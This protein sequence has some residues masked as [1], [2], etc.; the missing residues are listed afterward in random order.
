MNI[1]RWSAAAAAITALT[2]T[3]CASHG[4]NAGFTPLLGSAQGLGAFERVAEANWTLVDGVLAADQG[5]K[6]PAYLVTRESYQDFVIRAEVWVSDDAN[7][8]IFFRC[9]EPKNI[10]DKTCYEANFFDQ[11]PDPSYGTGA[12]VNIAKVNPMPKA[13]GR[14][15][16]MEVTAKGP[17]LTVVLNGQKTVDV[18]DRQLSKGPVALQWGRG[19]VKFRKVEIKAL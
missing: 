4:P 19:T 8:G 9:A 18:Q 12:I 3:G 17:Q 13:G 1:V 7:S 15:N 6:V 2:L 16:T 10:N 5:G 14:W 11:R